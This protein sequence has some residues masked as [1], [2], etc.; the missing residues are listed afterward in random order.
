MVLA[1]R[2]QACRLNVGAVLETVA[3]GSAT[4]VLASGEVVNRGL[5]ARV[6]ATIV[7]VIYRVGVLVVSGLLAADAVAVS[8]K[9]LAEVRVVL[10]NRCQ[11]CSLNG[12]AVL[13]LVGLLFLCGGVGSLV[14][15]LLFG[16]L[17]VL[18]RLGSLGGRLSGCFLGG[19]GGGIL[20]GFRSRVLG[21]S[22][23]GLFARCR[24]GLLC[25]LNGHGSCLTAAGNVAVLQGAGQQVNVNGNAAVQLFLPGDGNGEV[26]SRVSVDFQVVLAVNLDSTLVQLQRQNGTGGAVSGLEALATNV[27]ALTLNPYVGG[28]ELCRVCVG[29]NGLRRTFNSEGCGDGSSYEATA[30]ECGG[31]DACDVVSNVHAPHSNEQ[32]LR[33]RPPRRQFAMT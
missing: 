1:N 23:G 25:N 15:L 28:E 22:R 11:T 31:A 21:G 27:Q 17:L 8:I 33:Y 32:S 6:L 18:S 7:L 4:R 2:C 10:A 24:S 30:D 3:L 29:V 14:R 5:T 12:G 16:R 13:V 19:L 26:A 20:G 9:L